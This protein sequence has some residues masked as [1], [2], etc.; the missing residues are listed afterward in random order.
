[1]QRK[2]NFQEVPFPGRM[3]RKRNDA[4]EGRKRK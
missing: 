2:S 1:M 4:E 3:Q